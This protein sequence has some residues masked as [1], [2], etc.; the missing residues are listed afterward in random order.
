MI[1]FVLL[2]T[3]AQ[4]CSAS[5]SEYTA[6]IELKRDMRGGGGLADTALGVAGSEFPLHLGLEF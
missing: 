1:F 6:R 5:G 3:A 2:T 4:V